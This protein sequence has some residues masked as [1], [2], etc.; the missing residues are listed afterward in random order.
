MVVCGCVHLS[1]LLYLPSPCCGAFLLSRPGFAVITRL[2]RQLPSSA[3]ILL[4]SKARLARLASPGRRAAQSR[5]MRI[6]PR[7]TCGLLRL[8]ATTRR[9]AAAKV[10]ASS[11]PT[12]EP[13]PVTSATRPRC[14]SRPY[15]AATAGCPTCNGMGDGHTK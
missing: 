9:P 1:G 11:Q 15:A 5:S 2:R 3:S 14:R 10:L 6:S 13:A 7:C 12:P 4:N 8:T